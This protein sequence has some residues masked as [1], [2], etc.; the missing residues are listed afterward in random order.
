MGER[1]GGEHAVI[2]A[3]T[4]WYLEAESFGNCNCDYSCPCQF[5][6]RP[7]RGH[8]RGIEALRIT[9]GYFGATRLNGLCAVLTYAWPGAVYEGEGEMQAIIDARADAEQRLALGKILHGEETDEGANH[10][11]VFRAMCRTVHPTIFAPIDFEV[12]ITGR[13]ARVRI[14]DMLESEGRPIVSPATGKEHRVR[15]DLPSGIEFDLAEIG[16]GKTRTLTAIPIDVDDTYGQFN[17]LR[18]SS[19]GPVRGR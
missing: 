15:I 6:L 17:H 3:R 1:R 11:W 14:P 2:S 7:T 5:E 13:R 12:D 8:C 19:H 9:S 10:W 4:E 16:S 18:H